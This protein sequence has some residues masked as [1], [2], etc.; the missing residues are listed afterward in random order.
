[1]GRVS[2]EDKLPTCI[3]WQETSFHGEKSM[4][5]VLKVMIS[6]G[7]KLFARLLYATF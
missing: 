1:M 4:S 3:Q 7:S 2:I 6:K 5:I